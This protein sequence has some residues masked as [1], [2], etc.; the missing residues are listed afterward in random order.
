M[1]IDDFIELLKSEPMRSV[2][3]AVRFRAP[4]GRKPIAL[5]DYLSMPGKEEERTLQYHHVLGAPAS[6]ATLDEWRT[7]FPSHHLPVDLVALLKRVNGIHLWA[8]VE[9]SRAYQGLAPL[10]EWTLARSKLFG[11]SAEPSVLDERYVAISYHADAAAF[12]VL[13]VESGTYLLMDATAPSFD[14]PIASNV[15]ELL[16]WLWT[17]RIPPGVK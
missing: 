11:A 14:V 2:T 5:T 3:Q 8:G 17:Q 15:D 9:S 16:D 7:K 4:E 12:V 1:K 6:A 10:S 13:D